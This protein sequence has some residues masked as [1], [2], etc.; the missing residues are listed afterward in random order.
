VGA[1]LA[2]AEE[3]A[4]VRLRLEAQER[5]KEKARRERAA[6][7]A[8]A[9][10]LEGLAGSEQKL[11]TEVET[12]IATKQPRSYDRAVELLV[13]LRD[14]AARKKGGDFLLRLTALRQANERK[15]SLLERLQRVGL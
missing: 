10:Y 9:A 4:E 11:W 7:V 13:D 1:L 2:A 12:L 14:L 5:A 8:R 6:A 3:H 15:P